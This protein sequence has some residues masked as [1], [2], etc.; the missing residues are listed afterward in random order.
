[1]L[2]FGALR[3]A[4]E[5]APCAEYGCRLPGREREGSRARELEGVPNDNEHHDSH[6]GR[7][8]TGARSPSCRLARACDARLP[9]AMIGRVSF[10]PA[11]ETR[12]TVTESLRRALKPRPPG[13]AAR[14]DSVLVRRHLALLHA[15]PLERLTSL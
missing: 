8:L 6:P 2:A 12:A 1:M 11:R 10:F 7:S 4:R 9:A 15:S 14:A 5:R 3:N 13:R